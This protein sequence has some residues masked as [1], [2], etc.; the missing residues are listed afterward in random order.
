MTMRRT[1][2]RIVMIGTDP[3]THGGISAAIQ[4]WEEAGLFGR[5]PVIYVPTHRTGTRLQKI[6]RAL[7][8]FVVFLTLLVRIPCAVLHVHGASRASFWRKAAF[9]SLALAAKWP[10]VFHLHGGGFQRWYERD[11]GPLARA[12]IRFF[13]QR[14]A[15]VVVLSE[16]WRDWVRWTVPRSKITCIPNAV[17][18]PAPLHVERDMARIAFVGKLTAD[19]GVFELLE[20]VAAASAA[21]PELHLELAGEGDVEPVARR[22]HEL[23]IGSRILIRGWCPPPV[24]ER[25]LAR[26]GIFALPSHF[27]GSP[28]SLLE[29]MAAG[30]AVVA[31]RVGGIPDAVH[32]EVDGLL[33]PEGDTPALARALTR[34]LSDPELARRLGAAARESVASAHAPSQ[35]VERL[36]RLYASLGQH[37]A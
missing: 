29:A 33:V 37:P 8:A 7:D 28:M 34:L 32:D 9:M 23:G 20:A 3:A 1:P 10:I 35:A 13:L 31:T 17:P 2:T 6:L 27:E 22:A 30:C 15:R 12:V 21:C 24:R 36:G 4:A 5:W 16:A 19:K 11:C 25:I 26:A 18:L 14:A